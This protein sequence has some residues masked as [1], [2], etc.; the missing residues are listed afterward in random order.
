MMPVINIL[1]SQ[2]L[3]PDTADS[4]FVQMK[5]DKDQSDEKD[6]SHK[7]IGPLFQEL[8]IRYIFYITV[9]IEDHV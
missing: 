1:V 9:L 6:Y 5:H 3:N 2:S 8:V 7:D 4:D